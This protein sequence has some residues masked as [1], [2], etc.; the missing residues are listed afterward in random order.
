MPHY[1][2]SS[3]LLLTS[4]PESMNE[5]TPITPELVGQLLDDIAYNTYRSHFD[6][7]MLD[8]DSELNMVARLEEFFDM[9]EGPEMYMFVD[10]TM[11]RIKSMEEAL[12]C[13]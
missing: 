8:V 5:G 2:H 10:Q 4:S 6:N 1:E 11:D 3:S 13:L 9:N 7:E 12:K